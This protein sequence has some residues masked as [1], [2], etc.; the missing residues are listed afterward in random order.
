MYN[1]NELACRMSIIEHDTIIA[2][3]AKRRIRNEKHETF[4]VWRQGRW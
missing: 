2:F 4:H 3:S 1:L